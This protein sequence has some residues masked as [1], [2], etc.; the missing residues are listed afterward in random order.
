MKKKIYIDM[1]GTIALWQDKTI[2][3]VATK[4]YFRDIPVVDNVLSMVRTLIKEGS[5]DVCILSSVFKDKH[6]AGDKMHW[7]HKNLPEMRDENVFFV[8]YGEKKADYIEMSENSF[9]L[10]DLSKNLHEWEAAGGI[11]I[12]TYNGINGNNGTW[13]GFSIHSNMDPDKMYKQIVGILGI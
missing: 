9:L 3:E 11:G 5:M 7:L 12:K 2:E 1:D 6:S 8:P 10:D 13:K 4:G